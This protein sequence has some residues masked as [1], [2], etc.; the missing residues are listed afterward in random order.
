MQAWALGPLPTR[1]T[2]CTSSVAEGLNL[3]S[4]Y[5]RSGNSYVESGAR[6]PEETKPVVLHELLS[7]IQPDGTAFQHQSTS[8]REPARVLDLHARI[9]L[10]HLDG[11]EASRQLPVADHCGAR[12]SKRRGRCQAQSEK[13]QSHRRR[14]SDCGGKLT[15]GRR[16][17]ARWKGEAS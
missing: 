15:F 4:K 10:A 3:L 2:F 1:Q 9:Y 16:T 5:G 6:T 17:S 11:F 8:T 14:K 7:L 12:L 13:K